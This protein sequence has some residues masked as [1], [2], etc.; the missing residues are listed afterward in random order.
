MATTI[1]EL[2]VR[3]SAQTEDLNRELRRLEATAS[4]TGKKVTKK[5]GGIQTSL[6][7]IGKAAK[8]AGAAIAAIIITRKL[9]DLGLSFKNAARDAEEMENKFDA[10][11]KSSSKDVRIWADT[12]AKEVKRSRFSLME[13]ASTFQD[14]FV[15]LGFARREAAELSK[16]LVELAV[17]VSSFSNKLESDVIRDFQSALVGNHETVRKYGIIVTE[18]TLTQEALSSGLAN[19]KAEITEMNKVQA[20]L[21]LIM[22]GTAD[23]QGD[24]ARTA[25]S[26]ANKEKELSAAFEE[27]SITLGTLLTPATLAATNG[28]IDITN[29]LVKLF[30]TTE[31]EKINDEVE[32]L[33]NRLF[34]LGFLKIRLGK[35]EEGDRD[36]IRLERTNA[37]I[38]RTIDKINE[39]LA[40]RRELL[41]PPKTAKDLEAEA[42][43]AAEA[44][45]LRK[46]AAEKRAAAE[47]EKA[48]KEHA[49]ILSKVTAELEKLRNEVFKINNDIFAVID[50]TAK[51]ELAAFRKTFDGK[52]GFE[53]QFLEAKKLIEAKRVQSTIEAQQKID[54]EAAKALEKRLKDEQTKQKKAA[55]IA[56]K[57]LEAN[58]RAAQQHADDFAMSFDR[59]F[60]DLI[61]SG[62]KLSDV[63]KNLLKDLARMAAQKIFLD[64]VSR[65]LGGSVASFFGFAKGGV[66]TGGGP[67]SLNK[68]AG[69][70]IARSPQLALFGEGSRPEAF[71]PLPDGRNIPVKIEGGGGMAG[72]TIVNHFS[73]V[74]DVKNTVRAEILAAIPLIIQATKGQVIAEQRGIR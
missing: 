29:A 21:N 52:V 28:L 42:A 12:L 66:M 31:L 63:L 43:D 23:A 24:A 55:D 3:F 17:D 27:L 19:T 44:A 56:R 69:G 41:D 25:G 38:Q 45:A 4:R 72:Q 37:S 59:A 47:A 46:A 26:Q 11:F 9:I 35:T 13:F 62:G 58:M 74:T 57:T 18:A 54:E 10:V 68:Y 30:N 14:T 33:E 53:E 34:D 39:L 49:K 65:S 48:A 64:A 70:G 73:F 1:E 67:A 8:S 50:E 2:A 16:Q 60:N 20:R 71:V 15:P 6:N 22:K 61:F 51:L 32:A 5:L 40:K 7:K 36:T